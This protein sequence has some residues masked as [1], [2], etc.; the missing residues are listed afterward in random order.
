MRIGKAADGE[1]LTSQHVRPCRV[2][3]EIPRAKGIGSKRPLSISRVICFNEPRHDPKPCGRIQTGVTNLNNTTMRE[4]FEKLMN[5]DENNMKFTKY[6]MVMYGIVLPLG[7]VML[8]GIV[9]WLET[10][11]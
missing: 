4:F 8:M 7:L 3:W 10:L 9:G 2:C 5:D 1:E 6:E 11:I